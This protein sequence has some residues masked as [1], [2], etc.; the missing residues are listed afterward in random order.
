MDERSEALR[1]VLSKMRDIDNQGIV[2]RFR[3][4]GIEIR[5]SVGNFKSLEDIFNELAE[6][7]KDIK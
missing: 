1:S 3:S 4:M 2:E 5:D 7:W 6:K